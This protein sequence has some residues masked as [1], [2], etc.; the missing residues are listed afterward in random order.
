M[1]RNDIFHLLTT[2][3]YGAFAMSPDQT[4]LFWNEGAERILGY[5]AQHVIGRR[6]YEVVTGLATGGFSPVCRNGCPSIRAVRSGVIPPAS[7]MRMLCASGERKTVSFTPLVARIPDAPLLVYLFHDRPEPEAK[8]PVPQEFN[9]GLPNQPVDIAP[10]HPATQSDPGGPSRL[11]PREV[12]VLRLVSQGW[13]I[14]RIAEEL[15]ISPHTVR[16]HI[17]NLR[18]RLNAKTKLDAVMI[19]M[20]MGIL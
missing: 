1:T 20:R 19:A 15:G 12:E 16:N 4:I 11:T 10:T 7:K 6:C 2:S 5:Q 9:R 14:Q 18:Q 3:D 17:R 8:D 13:V